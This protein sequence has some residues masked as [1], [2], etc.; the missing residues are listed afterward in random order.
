MCVCVYVSMCIVFMYAFVHLLICK[1]CT[2]TCAYI[3]VSYL[4]NMLIYLLAVTLIEGSLTCVYS[5]SNKAITNAIH[6]FTYCSSCI[7]MLCCV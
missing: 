4:I 7:A 6:S 5:Y 2:S 3:Y 1:T